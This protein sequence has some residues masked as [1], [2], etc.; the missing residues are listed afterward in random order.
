M[1]Y[2]TGNPVGSR[3]P[4]DLLD[5]AENLDELVNSP[6][7]ESHPDRLGVDRKTWHGMEVDF[8]AAQVARQTEFDADQVARQDEFDADQADRA[9]E[10]AAFLVASGYVGTGTDGAFE[11][12]DADGPLTITAYN[13]VFTKDGEFYRAKAGTTLPYTTT[14][15]WAT[16]QVDFVSVGDA[17]L[18]QELAGDAGGELVGAGAITKTS[19]IVSLLAFS[20]LADG[21]RVQTKSY[22]PSLSIGGG[23]YIWSSSADKDDH[24]G[25]T[26]HSPTVPWDGDPANLPDYLDGTGET[27]PGGT[28]CW[29][30]ETDGN[31]TLG[32]AGGIPDYSGDKND[33]H[34]M[35]VAAMTAFASV[36]VEEGSYY[37]S[38]T[39]E[40]DSRIH[41]YG[42]VKMR[43]PNPQTEFIWPASEDH[44]FWFS[45]SGG[46]ASTLEGLYLRTEGFRAKGGRIIEFN[47][48]SGRVLFAEGVTDVTAGDYEVR[49]AREMELNGEIAISN[50]GSGLSTQGSNRIA[51]YYDQSGDFDEDETITGGT[52]GATATA[53]WP[54]EKH[55]ALI[56]ANISGTFAA[57]ETITGGTSGTTATIYEYGVDGSMG[58]FTKKAD[59]SVNSGSVNVDAGNG[60]T[61]E[62]FVASGTFAHGIY[63][64]T[65]LYLKNLVVGGFG[66]DGIAFVAGG[67]GVSGNANL[68]RIDTCSSGNNGGSG[69]RILG[70]DANVMTVAD[71]TFGSGFGFGVCDASFLGCTFDTIQ[72]QANLL[73]AFNSEGTTARN[74]VF[75]ECYAEGSNVSFA[76][77]EPIAT[78]ISGPVIYIGGTS[79]CPIIQEGSISA[80]H[81]VL[82]KDGQPQT[83]YEYNQEGKKVLL[84]PDN[85]TGAL[86]VVGSSQSNPTV[87]AS[88]I[89]FGL[90]LSGEDGE[91]K[92]LYGSYRTGQILVGDTKGGQKYTYESHLLRKRNLGAVLIVSGGGGSGVIGDV[93]TDGAGV[94]TDIIISCP[95][96]GY[97][98]NPTLSVNGGTGAILHPVIQ[99]QKLVAVVVEDGG[100]G[101]NNSD[102][103]EIYRAETLDN[104]PALVPGA[105][106][107]RKLGKAAARWS[108]VYAGTGT[109][110]T[111]DAN[112]KQQARPLN[113]AEQA[114]AQVCKGLIRAYKFNDAVEAKGDN[115]RIHIGVIAQDVEQAFIDEGLDPSMYAMFCRDTWW[116]VDG[117][118]SSEEDEG[119]VMRERLGIRY[120]ELLAFIIGAL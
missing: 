67:A 70:A 107:D 100:S 15:T 98:S 81:G 14:G 33:N 42:N 28:G 36:F 85:G 54:S 66:G 22:H 39:V 25:V 32:Q 51:T 44:G 117:Q 6:T 4:K 102:F 47:T 86:Y 83:I 93:V 11:D 103:I 75:L 119:A 84:N 109:I 77:W 76:P 72:V 118:P 35:I 88:G 49:E 113:E 63:S 53:Y 21:Q 38:T 26:I 18:R 3:S 31:G 101:Y 116:E 65:Q 60:R 27:D 17:A 55:N 1:S 71:C 19:S 80:E 57:G 37:V 105:D 108:T 95:G 120:D 111:S 45:G 16:D 5:N 46:R 9:A 8:D 89:D 69:I 94:I 12:Y 82:M 99:D 29:L 43:E 40:P 112:E 24:N 92:S 106:N 115:A 13:E 87:K 59:Y 114:V 97:T 73:G 48:S 62:V 58:S 7:K 79:G 110:N 78:R 34:A 56:L 50:V 74:S 41:I 20:G 10:F 61:N 96:S 104:D 52:S 2:D 23:T 30:L 91:G 90:C 68:S 64:Q